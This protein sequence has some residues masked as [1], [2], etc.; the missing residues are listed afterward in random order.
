LLNHP[1]GKALLVQ[2]QKVLFEKVRPSAKEGERIRKVRGKGKETQKKFSCRLLVKEKSKWVS[3]AK[4]NAEPCA[5]K[6]S[7]KTP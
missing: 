6:E 4:K 5:K 2:H 1:S 7:S 3:K